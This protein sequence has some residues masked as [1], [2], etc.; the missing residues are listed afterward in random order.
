VPKYVL[1]YESAEDVRVKAPLHFAAHQARWHEFL[2]QGTLL[3]IGTFSDLEGSMAVFTTREAAE[4][5]A[6]SDPFVVNGVV[7]SWRVRE[8]NEAIT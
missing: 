4:E 8:W 1:Q 3:M 5:F 2:D 7:S 6:R